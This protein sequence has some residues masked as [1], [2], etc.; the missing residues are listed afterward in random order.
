MLLSEYPCFVEGN[1]ALGGE[2]A[3]GGWLLP[4]HHG[5]GR[6]RAGSTGAPSSIVAV[7]ERLQPGS[8]PSEVG[9][10]PSSSSRRASPS[11]R[12]RGNQAIGGADRGGRGP[13]GGS[14]HGS[15]R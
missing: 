5:D 15:S 11:L 14:R 13:G 9:S 6:G 2:V 4:H 8:Y 1:R 7:S 3:A 10:S 12:T